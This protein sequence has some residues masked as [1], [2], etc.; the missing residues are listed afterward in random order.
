[1]PKLLATTQEISDAL[2]LLGTDWSPQEFGDY[3]QAATSYSMAAQ[4]K[5][6]SERLRNANGRM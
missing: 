3:S 6:S 4:Q 2:G 1:L 5:R